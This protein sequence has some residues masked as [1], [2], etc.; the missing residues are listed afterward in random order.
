MKLELSPK[1]KIGLGLTTL[2]I[3]ALGCR[4][5]FYPNSPQ[6]YQ[7]YDPGVQTAQAVRLQ[8]EIF[9]SQQAATATAKVLSTESSQGFYDLTSDPVTCTKIEESISQAISDKNGGTLPPYVNEAGDE[10][11]W[12][13][14]NHDGKSSSL[15]PLKTIMSPNNNALEPVFK[16]DE[17]C[18]SYNRTLLQNNA[19]AAQP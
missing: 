16:G 12:V 18:F 11:L 19:N 6:F 10:A 2:A 17:V 3:A 13:Y 14:V 8:N 15:V 7:D 9:Q 1:T 4:D 5:P